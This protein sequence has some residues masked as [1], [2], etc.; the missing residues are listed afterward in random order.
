MFFLELVIDLGGSNTTIFQHKKGLVLNE[1]SIVAVKKYR[2]KL[3]LVAHGREAQRLLADR[4]KQEAGVNIL[5]PI[6]EGTINNSEAA[7]LMV[8]GFLE[9]VTANRLIRPKIDAIVLI[10]CGT[11][12]VERKNIESIFTALGIKNVTL[13]ESPLAVYALLE[14]PYNFVV[15][16][17]ATTTEAAIIGPQGII[18]GCSVNIAGSTMD[19]AIKKHISDQYRLVISKAKAEEIRIQLATLYDNQSISTEIQGR[20]LIDSAIR[21]IEI[22]SCDIRK[23]IIGVVNS[24]ADVIESVSMLC[25]ENIAEDIYN[26]G[27][28]FA[29]GLANIHGLASYLTNRL[30]IK[31]NSISDTTAIVSGAATYLSDKDKLYTMIGIKEEKK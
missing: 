22:S 10:S 9:T 3:R 24:L 19:D 30:K 21:K 12:V 6:S 2:N 4:S 28:T 15:I 20:D 27:I 8:K 1:P 25:P 11:T 23:A 16:G 26:S 31:V 29:G 13:I 14:N 7:K 17:G 5:Y 18:T